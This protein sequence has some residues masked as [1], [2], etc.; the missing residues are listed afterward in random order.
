[1]ICVFYL[2]TQNTELL[3]WPM[4]LKIKNTPK[5]NYVF[6]QVFVNNDSRSCSAK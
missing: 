1:M 5:T 6:K 2:I 3:I 4:Y